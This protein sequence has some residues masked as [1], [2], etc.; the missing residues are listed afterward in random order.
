MKK[1]Q[2]VILCALLLVQT[3]AACAISAAAAGN[4]FPRRETERKPTL[5]G[6]RCKR[7]AV[8]AQSADSRPLRA[9][10]SR[11]LSGGYEILPSRISRPR[12]D[13]Y[14]INHWSL[15][16]GRWSLVADR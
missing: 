5:P 12:A 6:R 13:R 8:R 10:C 15:V 4:E 3:G 1:I 14:P 9:L 7:Y 16:A 2:C 11:R